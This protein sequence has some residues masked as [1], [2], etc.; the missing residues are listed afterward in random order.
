MTAP[1]PPAVT[2]T[3][4]SLF[5]AAILTWR[6]RHL[7][8]PHRRVFELVGRASGL[9]G[10]DDF[11]EWSADECAAAHALPATAAALDGYSAASDDDFSGLDGVTR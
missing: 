5:R 1:S 4:S 6:R 10:A 9:D 7:L 8:D 11:D 2:V 3:R